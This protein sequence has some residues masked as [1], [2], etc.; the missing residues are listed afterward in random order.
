[1]QKN[2][3]SYVKTI[4]N[5][6]FQFICEPDAQTIHAKD[7]L[8]EVIKWIGDIEAYTKAQQAPSAETVPVEETQVENK[9]AA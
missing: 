1:M 2:L 3:T 7:F 8:C 6:V 5:K 9:E 4:E